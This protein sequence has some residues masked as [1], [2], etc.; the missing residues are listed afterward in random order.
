MKSFQQFV[1]ET[2]EQTNEGFG[3]TLIGALAVG[4]AL[5]YGLAKHNNAQQVS[6]EAPTA[7]VQPAVAPQARPITPKQAP[8]KVAAPA[9]QSDYHQNFH[10]NLAA[11]YGSEYPVIMKA[12]I[13]N[14]IPEHDY[15]NLSTL[16]AIRTAENGKHGKQ[17]G[18]LAQG[19]GAKSGESFHQSLDRQAGWA[20]S[21]LLKNRARHAEAGNEG[22]FEEFMGKRWAPQGVANDPTNLNKNWAGNVNR[23]KDEITNC[24]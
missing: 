24:R 5:G 21:S 14:N 13:R 2:P 9:S 8:V 12:A 15:D 18:V 16:F 23:V 17:F 1:I 19:A 6:D 20:A 22:D 10:A 4:G 11:R 7:Q 3:N